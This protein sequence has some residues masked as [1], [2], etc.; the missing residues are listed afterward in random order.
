MSECRDDNPALH[1]SVVVLMVRVSD[2]P[3]ESPGC[4]C[5]KLRS[6]RLAKNQIRGTARIFHLHFSEE[7]FKTSFSRVA[8]LSL[9]GHRQCQI[10]QRL[11]EN[12]RPTI[13]YTFLT[14]LKLPVVTQ[15]LN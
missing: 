2:S 13:F 9:S 5:T 4:F 6:L 8:G 15:P 11:A 7:P 3:H 14:T 10:R 12:Y 1:S